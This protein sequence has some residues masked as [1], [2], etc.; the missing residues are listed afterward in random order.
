MFLSKEKKLFIWNNRCVLFLGYFCHG[1]T[2]KRCRADRHQISVEWGCCLD[3]SLF[4]LSKFHWAKT[5]LNIFTFEII[6]DMSKC[7]DNNSSLVFLIFNHMIPKDLCNL[8]NLGM[9]S[10]QEKGAAMGCSL[11]SFPFWNLL[12]LLP[13]HSFAMTLF[14]S[15]MFLHFGWQ[16]D[17][18]AADDY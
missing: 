7:E 14:F 9:W 3:S 17:I 1:P 2:S 6:S 10:G 11:F 8:L 13:A 15:L 5:Y 18:V 4:L 16:P 12:I